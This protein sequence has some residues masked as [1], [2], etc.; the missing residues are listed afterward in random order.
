MITERW[1]T[2]EA[3]YEV[4][5]ERSQ[6]IEM[7]D[8]VVLNCDVFRPDAPGQFPV[9]VSASP[10][11]L[12]LQSA[13]VRPGAFSSI[14]ATGHKEKRPNSVMEAGD[15]WF[16]ARRGYV[17]IILNVRGTGLSEGT[18]GLM[19]DREVED[20]VE[21]IEWAAVQPW[22]TGAVGM[23]GV[24]YFAMIQHRVGGKQPPSLKC[25]FAPF[26]SGS[27]RDMVYHGGVLNARWVAGWAPL[28]TEANARIESES[29][30]EFGEDVFRE[31]VAQALADPDL[32]SNSHIVEV[33][34]NPTEGVNALLTDILLHPEDGPFWAE[35][36]ANYENIDVPIYMGACWGN[37]GIHLSPLFPAW[38]R[39]PEP[40]RMTV[41]PPMYLDRPLFQLQSESLRWFDHW[42]KGKETGQD[43]DTSVRVFSTGSHDW[44]Q[45]T[46]WPLPETRWIPFNLHE[47]GL[48]SERDPWWAEPNDT[49]FDSPFDRESVEYWTPSFVDNVQLIGPIALDL[50]AATT[51]TEVRWV[52]SVLEQNADGEERQLTKGVF[53]GRYRNSLLPQSPPYS[54]AYDYRSPEGIT[55]LQIERYQIPIIP[56]A[57]RFAPN[58]KLGIRVSCVTVDEPKTSLEGAAAGHLRSE[59]P[60]R[61]SIYHD[62]THRS[63]LWVPI[64]SGNVFGTYLSGG[65]GY[66]DVA[67]DQW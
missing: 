29:L 24:S 46:K 44:I 43:E 14:G 35:R 48:L 27:F 36:T 58:T 4:Q 8:G 66:L 7:S 67:G 6:R 9:I 52:V 13:P 61:I 49:F 28:L 26:G 15:P 16:Y 40:K 34:K 50:H 55:P 30:R 25:L 57:H 18:Y 60:A 64:T 33:L 63:R 54:P 1:T 5:V 3:A 38:D 21:A 23:F 42:L 19:N 2:S 31:K 22:S 32:A 37:Y 56:T 12:S 53:D 59:T 51:N 20:V 11:S 39:I 62:E 17:H 65:E 45:S 10:Y 41:G 47:R